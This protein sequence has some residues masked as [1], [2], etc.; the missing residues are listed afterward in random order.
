MFL[1]EIKNSSSFRLKYSIFFDL[2]RKNKLK[3]VLKL[4]L[5]NTLNI[6]LF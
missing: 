6:K 4:L 2:N 5:L 3:T 1:A